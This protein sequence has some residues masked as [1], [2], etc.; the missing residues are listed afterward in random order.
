VSQPD[1]GGVYTEEVF[2]Y[3]LEIERRRSRVSGQ[4]FLLLVISSMDTPGE[5]IPAPLAE[6][7]F[8]ALSASVRETDFV[9]WHLQGKIIGAV[10]IQAVDSSKVATASRVSERLSKALAKQLASGLVEQLRFRLCEICGD[11]EVWI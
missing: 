9:G 11:R 7:A 5:L 2:Q 1:S 10:L 8:A 4:S 3:F 6:K